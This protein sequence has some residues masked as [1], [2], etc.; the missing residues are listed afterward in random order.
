MAKEP[1]LTIRQAAERM[2]QHPD[3]VSTLCRRGELKGAYKI[4]KQGK[5]SHW[6]IPPKAIDRYEL[7][8]AQT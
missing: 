8:R 2:N 4:G 3:T 6:R 1:P 5:T 7:L